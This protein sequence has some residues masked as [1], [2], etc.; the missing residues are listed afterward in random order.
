VAVGDGLRGLLDLVQRSQ[1]GPHGRDAHQRQDEHDDSAHDHVEVSDA[2][3]RGIDIAEIR[4]D[5]EGA[6][7]LLRAARAGDGLVGEALGDHAPGVAAGLRRHGHQGPD[8]PGP[9]RARG[10]RRE[11]LPRLP[12]IADFGHAGIAP[13]ELASR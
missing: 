7:H 13:G 4:A 1:V 5:D 3:D 12:G 2:A 6:G 11:R 9:A 10:Q 8:A